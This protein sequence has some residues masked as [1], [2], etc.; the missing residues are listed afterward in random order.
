M[1]PDLDTLLRQSRLL[2]RHLRFCR[3]FDA[4]GRTRKRLA[5]LETLFRETERYLSRLRAEHW[6]TDGTLLG[7]HREGGIIPHDRD[8]D[9]GAPAREFGRIWEERGQL[10]PGFKM[11]DT[12]RRHRGPKLYVAHRGWEADIYFYED[13]G[14]RLC[15]F[16]DEPQGGYSKPFPKDYIYPLQRA[17]FLGETTWAPNRVEDYLRHAYGYIGRDAVQDGKTGYWHKKPGT[18]AG[19]R[20]D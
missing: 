13:Q 4:E 8:I 19:D 3:P 20:K 10:P 16:A 5:A 1:R 12:S 7:Y 14:D 9:I 6:L 2:V 15:S 18:A 17:S 11:Y